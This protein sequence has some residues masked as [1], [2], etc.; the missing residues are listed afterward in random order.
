MG[1][2]NSSDPHERIKQLEKLVEDQE[3]QIDELR[4]RVENQQSNLAH[5][6]Q[7]IERLQRERDELR[8]LN[9]D[10]VAKVA[11]L[12]RR[13]VQSITAGSSSP[14][15]NRSRTSPLHSSQGEAYRLVSVT[16]SVPQ[17]HGRSAKPWVGEKVV[18]RVETGPN[19]TGGYGPDAA[20]RAERV[21]IH[22]CKTLSSGLQEASQK[23][24]HSL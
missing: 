12:S 16:E 9:A 5:R 6:M 3:E 22:V 7:V 15:T 19:R 18:R 1:S 24:S 13:H 4:G 11:Q 2:E 17:C 23:Q 20:Q 10:L 14:S 21:D 8:K